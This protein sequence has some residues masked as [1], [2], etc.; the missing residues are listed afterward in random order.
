VAEEGTSRARRTVRICS[1][2][3]VSVT[4]PELP[5]RVQMKVA[6]VDG[7]PQITGLRLEPRP[8]RPEADAVITSERLRSLPL[9]QLRE[10][11]LAA[12]RFD[13]RALARQLRRVERVGRRWPE[14]HYRLVADLYRAA[15]DSG[16]PPL[17][18]IMKHWSVSRPA[19]SKYVR[20]ARRRGFLG[21]PDRPGVAGAENPESPIAK[22]RPRTM[23]EER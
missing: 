3:W 13:L 2:G 18:V 22:N 19:A 15:I 8:D 21:Y 7:R 1:G 16:Q 5:W 20:E 9:R 11:A 10:A 14:E 12:L 6:S 4:R 23:Q 17:P